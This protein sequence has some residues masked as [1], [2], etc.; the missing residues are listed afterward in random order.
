[1]TRGER[2]WIAFCA[3]LTLFVAGSVVLYL[4]RLAYRMIF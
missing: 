3:F 1:M 2:A 4:I